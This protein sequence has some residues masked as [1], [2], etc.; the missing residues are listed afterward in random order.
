MR[1]VLAIFLLWGSALSAQM[2]STQVVSGPATVVDGDTLRVAGQSVRLYGID[3][4]EQD[5]TC[6]TEQQVAYACGDIATQA[7]T[8]LIGGNPVFCQGVDQD[9][10]GRV[11]ARCKVGGRDIAADLVASGYAMAYRRYSQDYVSLEDNAR[12]QKRG[13]WSGA[14][15]QPAAFRARDRDPAPDQSCNLKGNISANG[16]IVHQPGDDSYAA[17]RINTAKGERW[18][19]SLAEAQA[20]GWR[21]ARR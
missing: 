9:R 2:V 3:T 16:Q 1:M 13:F 18:F 4:P 10:Y 14:I 8:Q 11:V 21:P 17:T 20:A 12:Q 19:C 7:T 5:Q 15:Q 6:L